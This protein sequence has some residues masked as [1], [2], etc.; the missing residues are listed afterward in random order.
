MCRRLTP[1][2]VADAQQVIR[3]L[4]SASPAATLQ[5]LAPAPLADAYPDTVAC[6]IADAEGR[7]TAKELTW[8]YIFDWQRGPVF[9]ARLDTA[10]RPDSAWHDSL[11]HRRCLV[12]AAGFFEGHRAETVRS[13]RTGRPIKRQY[14]FADP[15]CPVLLLAGIYEGDRFAVVTT[16][17]SPDVAPI[18][19][20]MPLV[21]QPDEAPLW[22]GGTLEQ[23]CA[24]ASRPSAPLAVEPE[25]LPA[26]PSSQPTL[27]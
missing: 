12:P 16:D 23:I 11:L 10:L 17:P 7:L 15:A 27:F 22:L 25:P 26:T 24:L 9:N 13:P 5:H 1:L 21:L 2:S 20:R 14:R 18:H 19:D 3:C 4:E 8:G 6:T